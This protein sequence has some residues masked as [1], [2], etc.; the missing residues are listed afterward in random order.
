[1]NGS[2]TIAEHTGESGGIDPVDESDEI[3]RISLSAARYA[4]VIDALTEVRLN[5]KFTKLV[6]PVTIHCQ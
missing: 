5:Y 4:H 6:K 3:L 1:M 2:A